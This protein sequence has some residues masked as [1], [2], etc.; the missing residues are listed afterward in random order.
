MR[1]FCSCEK[2][3]G[4]GAGGMGEESRSYGLVEV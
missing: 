4:P 2:G 3:K 1:F